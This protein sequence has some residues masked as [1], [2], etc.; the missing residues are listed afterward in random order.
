[1]ALLAILSA[2]GWLAVGGFMQQHLD[3]AAADLNAPDSPEWGAFL[4]FC[5]RHYL[6][7]GWLQVGLGVC[8]LATA[9]RFLKRRAWAR[10]ALEIFCWFG[11]AYVVAMG[12]FMARTLVAFTPPGPFSSAVCVVGVLMLIVATAGLATFNVVPIWYLRGKTVRTA[13]S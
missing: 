2:G 9:H 7:C 10:S 12:V 5:I 3:E 13:V 8:L 6:V 1:M 11:L 4:F